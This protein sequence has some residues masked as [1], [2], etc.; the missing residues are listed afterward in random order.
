MPPAAKDEYTPEELDEREAQQAARPVYDVISGGVGAAMSYYDGPQET[1]AEYTPEEL[2]ARDALYGAPELTP[3][4]VDQRTVDAKYD[5]RIL[6]SPEQLKEADELEVKLT[7]QGKRPGKW[8]MAK[9]I[10]GGILQSV[11]DWNMALDKS[12]NLAAVV[13]NALIKTG[14]LDRDYKRVPML[15]A[16]LQAP[17][18]AKAGVQGTALNTTETVLALNNLAMGKPR[19]RVQETGEFVYSPLGGVAPLTQMAGEGKTLVPVTDADLDEH[20]YQLYAKENAIR[21]TYLDIM[22]EK[23]LGVKPNQSFTLPAEILLA[24]ENLAPGFAATRV[25]GAARLGKLFSAKT[26]GA[27]EAAAGG[28]ANVIDKGADVFTRAVQKMTFGLADRKTQSKIAKAAAYGGGAGAAATMLS[29]APEEARNT[30]LALMSLYPMYKMG[31]GVLR[32]VE[33]AAGTAKIIMRE[34]A[35]ATN[36]MDDVAR[37]AV[38]N[39]A[40][41]PR[42]IREAL[43]NPSKFVPLEST[44]ARIAKNKAFSPRVREVAARLASPLIVQASRTAGAVARGAVVGPVVNIPF[45]EAYR[46]MGDQQTAEGIYGAGVLFGAGGGLVGRVAGARGRRRD[47]AISD[48]GRM[49]VDIQQNNAGELGRPAPNRAAEVYYSMKEPGRMLT[50]VELAGGDI[51]ALMRNTKFEDLAGMAAMQGFYRDSVDFI[52]LNGLDYDA[53]VKA[54]GGNG[55]AGYFLHAPEGQRARLFLNADARRTDVAPHEYGHALLASAAISPEMK[56]S[57]RASINQR[58]GPEKLDAMAREYARSVV[59]GRNAREFPG[60]KIDVSETEVGSILNELTENGLARGDADRLDWLRDEIFAE[61][62]RAAG[63][64]YAQIRRG[65]PAGFNPVGFAEDIL[66]ANARALAAAGAPI[67]PQ[68]GKLQAPPDRLF[69]DNPILAA[70]P[71]MRRNIRQYVSAYQQ[72]LNDPAHEAPVGA[73]LSR[74]GNPNDLKNNPNVTFRDYGNGRLE[75]ELAFID[76]SGNVKLKDKKNDPDRAKFIRARQQ[77]VR[78]MIDRGTKEPTDPTFGVRFRDGQRIVAGKTLP[79]RFDLT[80]FPAPLKQLAR[81]MEALGQSGETMQ[82]RYFALGK[83]KDVFKQGDLRNAQAINREVM[84][85]EWQATKDGNIN[86]FVVD[87]TQFRN[88]AMKAI[89]QRDPALAKVNWDFKQL[90]ADLRRVLDNHANGRDGSDGIGPE[91]RNAVN[92]L[93]GIGTKTNRAANPLTGLGGKGS[94]LKTLRLDAFDDIAGTGR[95]GFSFDYQKANGN[96]MPDKPAPRPDLDSDLPVRMPQQIPRD[97]QGMPDAVEGMTTDQLLRQYEENQGYLGLSTLGMREG[98]PVRGGA[99]QTRELLRR[100]EAISAELERRGVRSEDP[101]LQRALQR[102]G[103]AMPDVQPAGAAETLDQ[104]KRSQF[105]PTRVAA[106]VVGGFPEYLRPVAQFITD[107][108]QKLANGQMTRRDV[109]KA[110]VMTVASQ[111]SGARAVEVI[112]NNVAKDGVKFRPSKDFTT[113]DKQGRAAI[114]PEEAAAY[115]LGTDA[116]QRALNNFEAGRYNPEDW[117]ELVAIRKAY[118]DDRFNNLGAFN[119][120]NIRTMDKVLADLNA[121]RA[122]TGRVMDAVQQLRGIKTGKKG[123]IAH[124]LGIGDVPTIDAV[125]INFWLTGK[126]DIGKLNTRRAT[127]ARNIKNSISDKRVSQEMF[128]RIDQRINAL[129]DEVPGGAD[130]APEVWSHVMHHWL[131]DKSKGIETTHEGMYRAQAQF[132]P[133]VVVGDEGGPVWRTLQDAPVI[134]LKDLKGRKV[135]AAFADLTSAGKIYRGIDSSEIAVPIETHGGPEWPLLQAEKV[136]EE[137]NV[138]SNQGAGVSAI[139]ARRANEGAIML[140]AA[141]DKNAHVSNTETATAVIATNAAYA[142]DGRITPENLATLDNLVRAEIEDFPGI[143]SPNIMEYVNKLPFQGAKSR[144]RIAEILESKKSQDLGAANVQRILDEMRS[145]Q[146][147]G[148]RI[149]DAV[150]AIELTPGAPA[151]KLGEQGTLKH[152]SYQYAL[153]G[154]VIGRFARPINISSIFDDFYAKRRAEGKPELGDRRAFDLAK[155]M[156]EITDTIASRVPGTPYMSFKSPRHAQLV[157]MAKEGKWR[158]TDQTVRA[159]GVSP[160]AFIDALNASP[161]KLALDRYALKSLQEKLETGAMSIYQL[162]DAQVFFGIKQGDPA[163][164]YGQNPAAFGFGPNEKTLSLVLN[165]ERRTGGMADAIVVKALQEGVTA[166]DCFAVKSEKYPNGMLPSLYEAYGFQSTG[167][168]PFDPQFYSKTELADLKKYWKS[169]GWDESLG[170]PE[171]VLMKWRGNDELRT[172]SLRELAEQGGQSFRG[173]AKPIVRDTRSRSKSTSNKRNQSKRRVGQGDAGAGARSQGDAGGGVRLSGGFLRAYDELLSLSPDELRNL[174][175][176]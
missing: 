115:W 92:A 12:G 47:A 45:A 153:R 48:I 1:K 84:F 65:I 9:A 81:R 31:S 76:E 70:D 160:A 99:A 161:A 58:Y 44:P 2:D 3:E 132:M 117:K 141:M 35:D 8:Q 74:T 25:T 155:P 89:A 119:P 166:L 37:A 167:S 91:R 172:K 5:A 175:I 38:A 64:D 75:N 168:L 63:I 14:A 98:R 118:G 145:D 171:I 123:F 93:L 88:R 66:G 100:N 170:L 21:S 111:G 46:E 24:P 87:L 79:P 20:R 54:L 33:G 42:E 85:V 16:A 90:E 71:V 174:G 151:V 78:E 34:S 148:L 143:E 82:V 15:E 137:T 67:D 106:E 103:Q 133:D 105:I 124:L 140:I 43:V 139:K 97:A 57:A 4:E 40:A 23:L 120:E 11:A 163:S 86:A 156:Q 131:W 102:R 29:G 10:G 41:V 19:Y 173:E 56:N 7:E 61:E 53:N 122:D 138:W 127:L 146:Y 126:A 83:S 114:R 147:N 95:Q 150:L 52:P 104:L 130:I 113:A 128:R 134:T 17:A 69:K 169:I 154:R 13:E 125:E 116:G 142:R 68:T 162:G 30:A 55:T 110:Y 49:L 135:F 112:A 152:P 101:Q 51:E 94:A 77:Q 72:W 62:H 18:S 121:S 159:G 157:N 96:F 80:R 109:M 59:A 149:G 165:N 32:R 107:Q 60:Q 26:L 176:Q 73:P 28:S 50:D 39:N 164:A 129:R 6:L 22:D 158:S 136:G 108:R 36:G 27:A 144:A